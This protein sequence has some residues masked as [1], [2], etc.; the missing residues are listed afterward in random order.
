MT[1]RRLPNEFHLHVDCGQTKT[2]QGTWPTKT[3]V[4]MWFK[5]ETNLAT[6]IGM[7]DFSQKTQK[8]NQPIAW[9]NGLDKIGHESEKEALG[10]SP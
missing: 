8:R 4:K 7:L 3:F 1:C 5:K 10:K 6:M 9:P 2:E